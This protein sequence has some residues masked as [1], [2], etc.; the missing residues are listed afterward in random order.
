MKLSALS[1][2]C[3]APKGV[4]V[5]R[6]YWSGALLQG[7]PHREEPQALH[8]QPE[9]SHEEERTEGSRNLDG[10]IQTQCQLGLELAI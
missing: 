6:Q 7:R 9:F 4:D 8:D 1:Y 2:S 3:F 10:W 5:W